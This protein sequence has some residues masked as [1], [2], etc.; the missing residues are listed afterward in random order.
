MLSV[1]CHV[2]CHADLVAHPRGGVL[3]PV[4]LVA[5]AGLVPAGGG[6]QRVAAVQVSHRVRLAH[7]GEPAQCVVSRNSWYTNMSVCS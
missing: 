4:P 3:V 6:G 5:L 2:I 7:E 1:T